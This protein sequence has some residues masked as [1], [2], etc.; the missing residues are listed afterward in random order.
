MNDTSAASE[1]AGGHCA[2]GARSTALAVTAAPSPA[3]SWGASTAARVRLREELRE[4]LG[5][6]LDGRE[7]ER[8]PGPQAGEDERDRLGGLLRLDAHGTVRWEVEPRQ[9]GA[10]PGHH[11]GELAASDQRSLPDERGSR[12]LAAGL[13]GEVI[14]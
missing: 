4:R 5:R 2:S 13:L 3:C 12:G 1:P 9:V 10:G 11:V 14:G 6:E 8:E 7:H